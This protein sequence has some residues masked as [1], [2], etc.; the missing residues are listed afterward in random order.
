MF[1]IIKL[2][3]TIHFYVLVMAHIN[4]IKV[5]QKLLSKLYLKRFKRAYIALIL[6]A[7]KTLVSAFHFHVS[8]ITQL[9]IMAL[10]Q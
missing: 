3:H 5:Q 6:R 1:N 2:Q 9:L 7:K 10:M 4:K 8:F